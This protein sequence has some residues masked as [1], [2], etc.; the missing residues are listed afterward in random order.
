MYLATKTLQAIED[1][2]RKDQGAAFRGWLGKVIPHMDDAYRT[3][4]FPFRTH[5]G[6]SGV[7]N[8]CARAIW[9]GFRWATKPEFDG[10][11]LRLFN[12][13]H[14][15]EARFIA[16]LLTIGAE[17]YNQDE[18]GKQYRISDAGGHFG[19]SGD[20]VVVNIPDLPPDTPALLECKTSGEKAF[21]ELISKGVH[22]CKFEHYVQVQIYMRKMD[23]TVTLYMCVNK[24][25]DELYCELI[26][27][28]TNI[29]D[30]FIDRG[31][32]LVFTDKAP[33]KI[34]ENPGWYECRFCDHRPV[35]HLEAPVEVNCRTC[36]HSIVLEVGEWSCNNPENPYPK[37]KYLTKENQL[38]GCNHWVK[39]EGLQ[40]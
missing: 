5:L 36:Q 3:N 13:G 15:E 10:R 31:V 23:L 25:T 35:C 20:G 19:G 18:N 24:N 4:E 30:Q 27:L 12:R 38:A 11:I 8:K 29:A 28:D 9:Y 16:M 26:Y 21:K 33:A 6:A 7:G 39:H 2:I 14:L 40:S 17:V 22:E 32:N 1:A 37:H 34:S